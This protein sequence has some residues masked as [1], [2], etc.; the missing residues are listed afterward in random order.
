MSFWGVSGRRI[1]R[2]WNKYG[3]RR[4]KL[5]ERLGEKQKYSGRGEEAKDNE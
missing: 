4:T 2:G 1:L 5:K 3:M